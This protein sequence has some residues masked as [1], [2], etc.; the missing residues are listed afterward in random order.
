[1]GV[2]DFLSGIAKHLPVIKPPER[3]PSVKERIMWTGGALLLF[4]IMY[5]VTCLG[6]KHS[7]A[8]IDFLQTITAS[9][10][11]PL[12][13]AGIGPVVLSS[14]FLQLFTGAG[15]I[16]LNLKDKHDKQKFLEV[17]KIVAILLAVIEGGIFVLTGHTILIEGFLGLPI[18]TLQAIV[19]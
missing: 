6:V 12:L 15:L 1:M 19:I 7:A 11:G 10:I 8:G 4:F 3:P 2:I 18:E 14:I 9:N 5:N 16:N 13:T 17:Q